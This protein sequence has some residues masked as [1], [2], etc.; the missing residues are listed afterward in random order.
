L[1]LRLKKVWDV[2]WDTV[3]TVS[4]DSQTKYLKTLWYCDNNF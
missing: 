4:V 3:Y 1:K 2:F